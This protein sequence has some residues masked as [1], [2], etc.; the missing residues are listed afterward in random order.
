VSR[1][2]IDDAENKHRLVAAIAVTAPREQLRQRL[3]ARGREGAEDVEERLSSSAETGPALRTFRLS[4][5]GT[6][7]HGIALMLGAIRTLAGEA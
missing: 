6:I 4:N 3:I 5:T 2:V 1:G 7:E